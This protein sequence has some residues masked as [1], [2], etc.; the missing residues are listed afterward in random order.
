[1]SVRNWKSSYSKEE[2]HSVKEHIV[3]T[4]S[5]WSAMGLL[6]YASFS[7]IREWFPDFV[8]AAILSDVEGVPVVGSNVRLIQ[9][10]WGFILL[11][12]L[13]LWAGSEWPK[14]YLKRWRLLFSLAGIAMPIFYVYSNAEKI[15][16]GAVA[17]LQEYLRYWNAYYGTTYFIAAGN[18]SYAPMALSVIFMALWWLIWNISY[19]TKKRV[20]LGLFPVAILVLELI[21]GLSPMEDGMF[22]L[23][24]GVMLLLNFGGRTI[25]KKVVVIICLIGSLLL[26][27]LCFGDSVSL[28]TTEEK[29]QEV[30]NWQ[31]SF[32][33]TDLVELLSFDF[34]FSKEPVGNQTPTYTGKVI[35]EIEADAKPE[36]S[37]YLKG[38]YGTT[39]KNGTWSYEDSEFKESCREYSYSQE[40]L[41]EALFRMPYESVSGYLEQSQIFV[42]GRDSVINYV[43]DYV[44]TTGDVAYVPYYAE[45]D[46]LDE[47]Y[48][49]L[50][51]YLLKKEIGDKKI[52][53]KV[54][55]NSIDAE[56]LKATGVVAPTTEASTVLNELAQT[57]VKNEKE[58]AFFEE[59]KEYV[60]DYMQYDGWYETEEG[61]AAT[62][63]L[64]L[65][66]AKTVKN[67]L[68]MQMSYSLILDDLPAGA[69]PIEYAVMEGHEGYC[70]HFATAGTLLLRELGVPARYVSGYIV[71]PSDFEEGERG[72]KAEVTDYAAHTWVEIYL[73]N[74]GWIPFEMTPGYA[75]AQSIIP[76]E[77]D[78]DAYEER[79]EERKELLEDLETG[80]DASEMIP[81]EDSEVSEE[82]ESE[83]EDVTEG[84][85][86]SESPE[87]GEGEN[88]EGDNGEDGNLENPSD[89]SGDGNSNNDS[90]KFELNE[91]AVKAVLGVIVLI[92]LAAGGFLGLRKWFFQ[93]EN[94]LNSEVKRNLTRRAVKH[95]NK[96]MF[97]ML[98]LKSAKHPSKNLQKGYW[99]DTK[100]EE[101]LIAL[102]DFV[103]KEDWKLYMEIVKKMHYSLEDISTE[104]MIHCYNCYKKVWELTIR[105]QISDMIQGKYK[106]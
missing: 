23:F 95:I 45:Y 46:S 71:I 64:R 15:F 98:R 92:A 99:T 21:V 70:M 83:G 86:L 20:L 14:I 58:M 88:T 6:W 43:I 9:M 101:E 76:T 105:K 39:Y 50:G 10:E 52:S 31:K 54:I 72:Y 22:F 27:S 53:V 44:G 30:L 85:D 96:R 59:A 80:E 75:S 33:T 74:I 19:A 41:A 100:M 91:G 37:I 16:T 5:L 48:D 69:D 34:H 90:V 36:G 103:D 11:W 94:S 26:S 24:F 17:M 68:G 82:E 12:L 102:Y 73:D 57:Y 104:E 65:G 60:G 84:E 62:N 47:D 13:I 40:E 63:S 28:L 87:G 79:S 18:K 1:M 32:L 89:L 55:Q 56:V 81:E 61:T 106:K 4:V 8:E 78:V 49:F 66:Y 3:D 35:L 2:K 42:S 67:F 29:K 51:D 7:M 25:A 38:Y 93:Y 77:G 97:H